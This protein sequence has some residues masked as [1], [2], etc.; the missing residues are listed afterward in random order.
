MDSKNH[1]IDAPNE[2]E[3][4]GIEQITDR[5]ELAGV[6][7]NPGKQYE[8]ELLSSEERAKV[9]A[10]ELE[11][12]T[13][14]L[15]KHVLKV[16]LYVPYPFVSGLLI[17]VGLYALAVMANPFV[18]VSASILAI[19]FWMI[20]SY[21]AYSAIFKLFYKHA[22]RAG[23]FLIV[24]LVS[25][26]MA[27]QAIYWIVSES[28]ATQSLLSNAALMSLLLVVYSLVITYILLGVWGNSRLPSIIKA[29]L[30]A[31]IIVISA[32]FVIATYLF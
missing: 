29:M 14:G 19:G 27:S 8:G 13:S 26:A 24:S 7:R 4:S 21:S 31:L 18:I 22:L 20:S 16:G 28:Y 1:H 23:P 12:I 15:G 3:L 6:Y 11:A 30:S 32:F 2:L 25:I 9:K 17:A 10:E 5:S